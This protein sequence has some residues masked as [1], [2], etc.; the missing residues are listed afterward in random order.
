MSLQQLY[1]SISPKLKEQM[2]GH[3]AK[4]AVRF[5][6]ILSVCNIGFQLFQLLDLIEKQHWVSISIHWGFTFLN[7]ALFF[8]YF[9]LEKRQI[10]IPII[11]SLLVRNIYALYDFE[12]RKLAMTT[13]AFQLM[14]IIQV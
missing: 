2:L 10:I 12:G 8:A 4:I 13:Q 14:S 6:I 9:K 1:D 7:L 11:Y 3:H 5:C